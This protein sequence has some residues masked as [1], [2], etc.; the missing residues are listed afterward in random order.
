[1][2][3]AVAVPD[4]QKYPTPRGAPPRIG[5]RIVPQIYFFKNFF[6]I[7]V[8]VVACFRG[9]LVLPSCGAS[10]LLPWSWPAP[11]LPAPHVLACV[12]VCRYVYAYAC[13]DAD[14]GRLPS[15]VLLR[16]ALK[17]RWSCRKHRCRCRQSFRGSSLPALGIASWR[18][19][20][21]PPAGDAGMQSDCLKRPLRGFIFN[22]MDFRHKNGCFSA[23]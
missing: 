5:A 21:C 10:S 4:F 14:A 19:V 12:P 8:P 16:P 17:H 3:V 15:C 6:H 13:A 18:R 9:G 20:P 7:P 2:A 11:S 23:F 1:M 22:L